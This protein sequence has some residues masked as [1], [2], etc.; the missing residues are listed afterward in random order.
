MPTASL[1][2]GSTIASLPSQVF[3]GAS[4]YMLTCST[5]HMPG[6]SSEWHYQEKQ[7]GPNRGGLTLWLKSLEPGKEAP[8]FSSF[9]SFMMLSW[10]ETGLQSNS[11]TFGGQPARQQTCLQ[12]G[13][14]G[15][16]SWT[17]TGQEQAAAA[18]EQLLAAVSP[19]RYVICLL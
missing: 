16:H 19:L 1:Q 13:H 3:V 11:G 15:Q 9:S 17:C 2:A 10:Q 5:A 18:A 6:L 4:S 12:A 8:H 14:W 7:V